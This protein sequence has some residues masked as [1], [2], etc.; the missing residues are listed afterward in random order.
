MQIQRA[1]QSGLVAFL[2]L[3]LACALFAAPQLATYLDFA[4]THSDGTPDHV[5]PIDTILP[6]SVVAD[7]VITIVAYLIL[8][9]I[10]PRGI[11]R[12]FPRPLPNRANSIRAPPLLC[13]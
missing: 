7:A 8:V 6:S 9:S 4:H 5:H 3:M 12:L 2:V 13:A 1:A 11:T 10:L